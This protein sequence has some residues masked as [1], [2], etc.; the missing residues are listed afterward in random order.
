MW[1][2]YGMRVDGGTQRAGSVL[3]LPGA[4]RCGG[5]PGLWCC[6]AGGTA[7]SERAFCAPVT[8]AGGKYGGAELKQK[9]AARAQTP[10][11]ISQ[12]RCLLSLGQY[13]RDAGGDRVL[14]PLGHQPVDYS[15][16]ADEFSDDGLRERRRA[17]YD[18]ASAGRCDPDPVGPEF[19]HDRPHDCD[20]DAGLDWWP[21]GQ[22]PPVSYESVALHDRFDALR[23]RLGSQQ[24]DLLP[25]PPGP[26][27]WLPVPS[28]DDD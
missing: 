15:G 13:C 11:L 16:F 21:A 22:S 23:P 25:G 3:Y 10:T 28:R 1:V 17:G 2:V 12:I 26:E 5:A 4:D 19:I 14:S 8:A 27:C 7:V 24:P 20:A 18:D 9:R 6:M